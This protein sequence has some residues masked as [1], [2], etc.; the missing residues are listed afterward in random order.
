MLFAEE[1]ARELLVLHVLLAAALVAVSTHLVIWLRDYPRGKFT[2]LRAV[3]RFSVISA[4]LFVLTFL[5]G[6][7]IYPTYKVRVRA[8]YLDSPSALVRDYQ[9]RERER[10]R[11][12][13][14]YDTLKATGD[15]AGLPKRPGDPKLSG[16]QLNEMPMRAAKL[17][18]WFDVKEHWVAMGMI[19]A[20]GCMVILLWWDPKRHGGAIA[21]VVFG[22]AV[23][24]AGSAW[25][26]ALVGIVLSS[27][28]SIGGL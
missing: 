4:V 6:N 8:Q 23:C 15:D 13:D 3:R 27:Y 16:K 25:L 7:V 2:R 18:R 12:K 24:A 19:M 26:G 28:R 14:R 22:L 5:I 1:Y 11:V 17:A 20:I 21:K 10:I 9:L